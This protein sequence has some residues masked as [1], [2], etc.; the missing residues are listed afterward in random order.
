V[1]PDPVFAFESVNFDFDEDVIR[2]EDK[3]KLDH[4]ADIISRYLHVS[5]SLN[6]HT[7]NFGSREYNID[8]SRRRSEAVKAYLVECGISADRIAIQWFAF[9]VPAVENT[10]R[11]NR[12]INRRVEVIQVQF[13]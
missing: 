2:E 3:A 5:I 10:T 4:V 11:D 6:G 13:D 9:V 1:L 7:D 8:L 12:F